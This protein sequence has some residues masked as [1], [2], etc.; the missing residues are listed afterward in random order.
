VRRY[1]G[2]NAIAQI[3]RD[4]QGTYLGWAEDI[5]RVTVWTPTPVEDDMPSAEEVAAAVWNSVIGVEGSGSDYARNWLVVARQSPEVNAKLDAVA[6]T[7]WGHLL[8]GLGAADHAQNW[9]VAART[10]PEVNAKLDEVP[11]GVWN[12]DLDRPGTPTSDAGTYVTETAL[13]SGAIPS[14]PNTRSHH[15]RAT[16]DMRVHLHDSDV[17]RIA[18]AVA[19]ILSATDHDP[20]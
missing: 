12:Y 18:V 8:P 5:N 3:E 1:T 7:V 11:Q 20:R 19:A 4:F 13:A 9:L 16:E 15:Q 6:D 17:Q 10:Q 2:S 14:E